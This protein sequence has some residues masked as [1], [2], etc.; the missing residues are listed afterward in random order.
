MGATNCPE[1]PRQRMI[2]M[3]YLVLTAMLA[4]NVSKDI[5]DAFVVVDETLVTTIRNTEASLANDYNRLEQQKVILGEEKVKD[6]LSQAA[7]LKKYSDDMVNYIA[8]VK[9]DL[10]KA[11]ESDVVNKDGS[12]KS[13]KDIENKD[14]VSKPT[15]FFINN[16]RATQL[17]AE[18]DKYRANILSLVGDGVKGDFDKTMGLNTNERYENN[19]GTPE[20]WENHNFNGIIMIA[21]VTLLNKTM[22]EVRNAELMVLKHIFASIS[23]EDFKFDNVGGRAIPKTQM[24]FTGNNYEADIIVAAYD[25]KQNPEVYY[26][27][28]VDTLLESQLAGATKL[29]GADGLA[30]L[31]LAASSVGEFKY[32]GLI[33]VKKPDGTPTYYSFK[34]KYSVVRPSA[35]VAAD[36]MNVLYAGI[37]NPLSASAPV[38]PEKLTLT[39]AGCQVARNTTGGWDVS[40]P[41][42]MIGKPVTATVSA[43]NQPLGST[44]FRV[45]GVP[46]PAATIGGYIKGG[47]RAKQELLGSSAVIMAQMDRD[48]VYDMKWTV[49]S[50]RVSIAVKGVESAPL[51]ISGAQFSEDLKSRIQSAQPGTAIYF[52]DIKVSSP[53]GERSLD[54]I[55]VRIK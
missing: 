30:K 44:V 1:T 26:K 40:V 8:T 55:S 31:S 20:S 13:T 12:N 32:A 27:M 23:A 11:V 24:V 4:L 46:N 36:K 2:G 50:Y 51:V 47:K 54:D 6:A 18:I 39:V 34:D 3:M 48:F 42:S 35:T 19:D 25:S 22:G 10:F 52:T 28:G 37:P 16:K 14:N 53:A 33:M 38:P 43:E 41:T 49:K 15:D 17:K 29:E 45:K 9:K 7:Q 5:L 21:C